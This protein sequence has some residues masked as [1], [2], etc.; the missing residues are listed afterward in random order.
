[1]NARL[2]PPL[3]RPGSRKFRGSGLVL[4]LI[5]A[6]VLMTVIASMLRWVMTESSLN[7]RIMARLEAANAAEAVAEYGMVQVRH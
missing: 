1:M 7:K 3:H 2:S 5:Y 4:A 6:S